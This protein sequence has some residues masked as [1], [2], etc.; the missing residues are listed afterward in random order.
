[1][2]KTNVEILLTTATCTIDLNG[3]RNCSKKKRCTLSFCSIVTASCV[4]SFVTD[5]YSAAVYNARIL[6]KIYTP[7][8]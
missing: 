1:M 2:L 6:N 8:K 4:I 7:L 5:S 3:M